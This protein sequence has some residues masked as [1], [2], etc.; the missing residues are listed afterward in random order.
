M[1][2]RQPE[3]RVSRATLI[4]AALAVPGA[5]AATTIVAKSFAEICREADRIFVGTVADVGSQWKDRAQMQI[6]TAVR[7][8]SVQAVHGTGGGDV[9]LHFGGGEVDGIREEIAGMPKFE[10]GERLVIFARDGK[11]ISPIV[12][13]RQGYFR[14]AEGP[15]GPVVADADGRPVIGVENGAL[16]LG[17]PEEGVAGALSLDRFIERVY[18]AI[19]ATR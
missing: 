14:V 13:F 17:K 3:R 12:G 15:S 5:V 1:S 8:T 9:T 4:L 18:Q 19:D 16:L 2:A 10:T 11:S 7:F 6:E